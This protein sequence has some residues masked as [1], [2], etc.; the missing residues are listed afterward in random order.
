MLQPDNPQDWDSDL[1]SVSST[2][3][4]RDFKCGKHSEDLCCLAVKELTSKSRLKSR[5]NVNRRPPSLHILADSRIAQWPDNDNLCIVDFHPEWGFQNWIS[6]LRAETIRVKSNTAVLYLEK[7]QDYQDVVPIKN[8][9]QTICKTLKQHN[10]DIRIFIANFLPTA[11]RSPVK[12]ALAESNFNLLQAVRS[13]NRVLGKV[14]FLSVYEHFV[15]KTG[16]IIRPT[17]KFFAPDN[18]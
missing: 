14:H 7:C 12:T 6:A 15:S 2:T 11:T 1:D 9:L 16:S 18:K 8:S 17:H 13:V 10:R 5:V 4:T 3:S